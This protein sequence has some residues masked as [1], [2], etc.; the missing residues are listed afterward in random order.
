MV[1][2]GT[3]RSDIIFEVW[4]AQVP[5]VLRPLGSTANG[6]AEVYHLVGECYVHG[7][8]DGEC[9]ELLSKAEDFEI[10]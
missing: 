4:G 10:V 1:P 9:F 6:G 8:M 5:F 7:M 3:K 2:K